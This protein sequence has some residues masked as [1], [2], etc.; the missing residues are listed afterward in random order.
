LL[1]DEAKRRRGHAS[2]PIHARGCERV[3][4]TVD[5]RFRNHLDI[6]AEDV[7]QFEAAGM[8]GTRPTGVPEASASTGHRG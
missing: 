5:I 4:E 8:I 6:V 2:R 1:R 3:F 7:V